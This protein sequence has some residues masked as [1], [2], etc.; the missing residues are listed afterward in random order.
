MAAQTYDHIKTIY[1]RSVPLIQVKY[2]KIHEVIKPFQE[3]TNFL[4]QNAVGNPIFER[5]SQKGV[6]YSPIKRKSRPY[7]DI[8]G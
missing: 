4:I 6:Y 7:H 2:L 3:S 5:I 1:V 8:D